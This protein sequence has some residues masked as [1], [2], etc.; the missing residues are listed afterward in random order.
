MEMPAT[1]NK[2]SIAHTISCPSGNVATV[3]WMAELYLT[4]LYILKR[5][6]SSSKLPNCTYHYKNSVAI[7]AKCL[8]ST[9]G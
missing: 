3:E 2:R 5:M 7:L 8:V 4:L 6:K 9:V 1:A